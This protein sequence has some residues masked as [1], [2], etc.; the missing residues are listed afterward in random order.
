[1]VRHISVGV[2]LLDEQHKKLIG[3]VNR[4]IEASETTVRSEV[5]SDVLTTMTEYARTHFKDEEQ[6]MIA[7][8]YPGYASHKEH[9]KAFIEKTVAFCD[10]TMLHVEAV[11]DK[12]LGY[13]RDWWVHHILEEDMKYKPFFNAKGLT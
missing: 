11:P 6:Y 2:R 9:H 8:G 7:Y 1:V 10:A 4:L 5:I 12:L 3:M 13:L